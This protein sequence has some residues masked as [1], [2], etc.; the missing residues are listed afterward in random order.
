VVR[1]RISFITR[2]TEA[3]VQ[4]LAA[5]VLLALSTV[6]ALACRSD[7]DCIGGAKC[8]KSQSSLYG[9]CAGGRFPGNAYDRQPAKDTL[10]PYGTVGKTCTL[11]ADCGLGNR[12][13]KGS[14]TSGVCL[15]DNPNRLI[16]QKK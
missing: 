1:R 11:D 13:A 9:I 7:V 10:D 14:E 8:Q 12:C 5:L 15:S 16:P 6:Q 3:S 2:Q 4:F